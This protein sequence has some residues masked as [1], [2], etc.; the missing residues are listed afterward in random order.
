MN[1]RFRTRYSLIPLLDDRRMRREVKRERG[2]Y[3]NRHD[4]DVWVYNDWIQLLNSFG[5]WGDKTPENTTDE[6]QE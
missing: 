5:K 1:D 4:R 6:V 2:G 3:L